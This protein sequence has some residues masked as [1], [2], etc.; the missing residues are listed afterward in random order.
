M[1]CILAMMERHGFT[2]SLPIAMGKYALISMLTLWVAVE[3]LPM[4]MG[5]MQI[6][7]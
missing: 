6:R 1:K 5:A 2:E 4:R 7:R 3:R